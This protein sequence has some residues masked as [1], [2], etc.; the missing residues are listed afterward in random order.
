MTYLT[1]PAEDLH[2]GHP[3]TGWSTTA[4]DGG[5]G[6]EQRQLHFQPCFSAPQRA[7]VWA[8]RD[9][10][11]RPPKVLGNRARFH[12][13]GPPGQ[14][15]I[16]GRNR[17]NSF[18]REAPSS[19]LAQGRLL[20]G[21]PWDRKKGQ[22]R[23]PTFLQKQRVGMRNQLS[24]S[25]VPLFKTQRSILF[26]SSE[27]DTL[28]ETFNLVQRDPWAWVIRED[29]LGEVWFRCDSASVCR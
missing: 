19:R 18:C 15:N 3:G 13:A 23:V 7:T 4:G 22:V 1:L 8:Q 10:G 16:R 12:H 28:Q 14:V 6:G 17:P 21:L 11:G 24:P 26:P 27:A 25:S 2:R 9:P 5:G 20:P 29:F